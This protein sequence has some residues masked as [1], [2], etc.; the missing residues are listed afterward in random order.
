V[1][2]NYFAI[3]SD[4]NITFE[5]IGTQLQTKLESLDGVLRGMSTSATVS[6]GNGFINKGGQTL[7][8]A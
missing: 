6:K 4:P 3:S 5:P 2:K 8:H 1:I 7:L